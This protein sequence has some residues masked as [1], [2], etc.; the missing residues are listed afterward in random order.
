MEIKRVE[1]QNF[2][3]T[4]HK[5]VVK[6]INR[7]VQNAAERELEKANNNGKYIDIEPIIELQKKG[8]DLL[9]KLAEY[10]RTQHKDSVLKIKLFRN[11]KAEKYE[12][13]D[14]LFIENKTMG[15]D[16]RIS[17]NKNN[18]WVDHTK[19]KV[20]IESEHLDNFVITI[21]SPV[22]RSNTFKD[23]RGSVTIRGIDYEN[24]D[25]KD[26]NN[27]EIMYNVMKKFPQEMIDMTLFKKFLKNVKS[28]AEHIGF[29]GRINTYFNIKEEQRLAKQLGTVSI[30]SEINEVV[31]LAKQRKMRNKKFKKDM[32]EIA[33][34]NKISL[35]R[36]FDN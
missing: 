25:E 27:F 15:S 21:P 1:G 4:V 7:A 14:G 31:E 30:K 28:E 34:A 19:D 35:K 6:Y 8:K 33:K 11:L 5:S 32:K 13:A 3:G 23:M 29:F 26:L 16:I 36:V 18:F 2:T 17:D 22:E 24:I 9:Q 20:A 10:M 12:Y